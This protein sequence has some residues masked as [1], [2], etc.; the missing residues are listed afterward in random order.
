V[1]RCVFANRHRGRPLN[2]VVRQPK[3]SSNV[4][5][6]EVFAEAAFQIVTKADEVKDVV[7]RISKPLKRMENGLELWDAWLYVDPGLPN[8]RKPRTG[9]TSFDAIVRAVSDSRLVLVN[10]LQAK[11]IIAPYLANPATGDTGHLSIKDFYQ[12]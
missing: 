4:T 7:I 10:E 5:T 1:A 6:I 8:P 12:L 9:F 3:G 11:K 2:S